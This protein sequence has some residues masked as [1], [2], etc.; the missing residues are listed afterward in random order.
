VDGNCANKEDANTLTTCPN[1]A[2]DWSR[3]VE[4]VATQ[5]SG[6]FFMRIIWILVQ[7]NRRISI[8]S[9]HF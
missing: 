3:D 5:F 6:Q 7:Q 4:C 2:T 9:I 8:F 1:E